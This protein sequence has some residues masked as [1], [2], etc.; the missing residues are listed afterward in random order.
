MY[1]NN[2]RDLRECLEGRIRKE[3]VHEIATVLVL[4]S[5]CSPLQLAQHCEAKND[6]RTI[7]KRSK[8][9]GKDPREETHRLFWVG[10]RVVG[11]GGGSMGVE[12]LARNAKL[13]RASQLNPLSHQFPANSRHR[14]LVICS[15]IILQNLQQ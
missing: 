13:G 15:L 6:I 4:I 1:V 12:T 14:S 11:E 10:R 8:K 9:Q 2:E 3:N 7:R 5:A